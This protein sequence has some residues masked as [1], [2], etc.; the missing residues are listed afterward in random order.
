MDFQR[1]QN[2]GRNEKPTLL[3]PRAVAQPG[4]SRRSFALGM[5]VLQMAKLAPGA[6]HASSMNRP[7]AWSFA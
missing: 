2:K 6:L 7:D 4:S 3:P 5:V 1:K